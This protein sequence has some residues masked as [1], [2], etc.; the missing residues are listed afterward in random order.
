VPADEGPILRRI[1]RVGIV[2]ESD[3][4]ILRRRARRR[5]GDESRGEQR[6]STSHGNPSRQ[7]DFRDY[8]I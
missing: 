5:R 2:L 8:S 4:H 7:H 3:A 1:E 6:R